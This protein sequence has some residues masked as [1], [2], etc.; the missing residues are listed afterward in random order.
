MVRLE[1][2]NLVVKDIQPTLDFLLSAFPE[3]KVRG[4][5][6]MAWANGARSAS[7]HWVHLGDD[8]YYLTLN[9]GGEGEIRDVKSNQSGLAHLGFV[10]DDLE[11]VIERLA[12]KNFRVDIVG[13]DHPFRKT[14]YFTDPA[15]F[16]F[17]FLQY[18]SDVSAEKNM[19]GG[20]TGALKRN[21][22]TN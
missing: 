10:V 4:E 18:S 11:A 2:A 19:Y 3:W 14:V 1:H 5:G 22:N 21:E 13:R 15:G 20:E 9:D 17:E 7:R 16:Q 12:A 6:D 8:E